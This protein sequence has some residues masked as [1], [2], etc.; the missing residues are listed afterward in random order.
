MLTLD[1]LLVRQGDFAL[2][3]NFAVTPGAVTAVIGPSGGGKSTLLAAIAGFLKAAEGAVRWQGQ[4]L[5][6]LA[7]G[8]RPVGILFQDNNLFPHLTVAQN[9]GLGLRPNLR[10][11]TDERAQVAEI[12]T[13]MEIGHLSDRKP[14]A[15]SGGQQSRAGLARVVVSGRPVILLDE[16]FSALGPGLRG[17]MLALVRQ[18]LAESGATVLMVTHD[19]DDARAVA[20]ETIFVADG[21]AEA[22]RPT[23]VLL[24]SAHPSLAAYL[25]TAR[26]K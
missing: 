23:E 12:L 18:M 17:E 20:A 9:V 22:P 10:L 7:P 3:A 11:T 25:G 15:L 19:P 6:P 14:A 21:I 26:P 16:A 2:R 8:A 4:D 5:D 24:G 1:R 13:R